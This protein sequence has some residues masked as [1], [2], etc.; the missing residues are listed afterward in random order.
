MRKNSEREERGRSTYII[1]KCGKLFL[2]KIQIINSLQSIIYF[3]TPR[4]TKTPHNI[5]IIPFIREENC[6]SF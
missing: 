1:W 2:S 3:K 4:A 5:N 6:N